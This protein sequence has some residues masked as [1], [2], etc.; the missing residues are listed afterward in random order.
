MHELTDLQLADA[1]EAMK[2]AWKVLL[3]NGSAELVE[4]LSPKKALA[5]MSEDQQKAFA[6]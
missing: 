1:E 3:D 6:W 5:A 4:T 2:A